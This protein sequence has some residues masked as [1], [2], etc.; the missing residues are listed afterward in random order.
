MVSG[1]LWCVCVW[2]P[3]KSRGIFLG[4]NFYGCPHG[5][6]RIIA[7][8]VHIESF[9]YS[10]SGVVLNS[11]HRSLI[12]HGIMLYI[13]GGGVFIEFFRMIDLGKGFYLNNANR[14]TFSV[15]ELCMKWVNIHMGHE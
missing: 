8:D 11:D 9:E 12:H 14:N 4:Q 7:I 1:K 6:T 10:Q 5:A 3:A 13:V 2:Y 15:K